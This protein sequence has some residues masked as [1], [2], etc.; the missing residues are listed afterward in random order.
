M[1]YSTPSFWKMGARY[2][3][4]EGCMGFAFVPQSQGCGVTGGRRV[5]VEGPYIDKLGFGLL[6]RRRRRRATSNTE[7]RRAFSV[8]VG[9]GPTTRIRI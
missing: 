2:S 5:V 8:I 4:D 1:R 9:D 6:R 3:K 7:L